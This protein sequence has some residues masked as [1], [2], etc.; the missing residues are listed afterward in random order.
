MVSLLCLLL[1]Q[2]RQRNVTIFQSKDQKHQFRQLQNDFVSMIRN[3]NSKHAK[4]YKQSNGSQIT[5]GRSGPSDSATPLSRDWV[6][7]PISRGSNFL[8]RQIPNF[9]SRPNSFN[10][11]RKNGYFRLLIHHSKRK[12]GFSESGVFANKDEVSESGRLLDAGG[13]KNENADGNNGNNG[14]HGNPDPT[15]DETEAIL[16]SNLQDSPLQQLL[17]QQTK[18]QISLECLNFNLGQ[19]TQCS[20][21][22]FLSE[23]SCSQCNL[24]FEFFQNGKCQ[25]CT[26]P[27]V[28][29]SSS[30][31]CFLCQ[32]SFYLDNSACFPCPANCKVCT[33]SDNCVQC[34]A[35]YVFAKSSL[36]C[37]A[38]PN[39]P[40]PNTGDTSDPGPDSTVLVIPPTSNASDPSA[41][42]DSSATDI[43]E[44]SSGNPRFLLLDN[45]PNCYLQNIF[46][47]CLIC[48]PFFFLR[49][50]LCS[51]CTSNCIF[52]NDFKLCVKCKP[53]F[54][55]EFDPDQG[56]FI[57]A[58]KE[59]FSIQLQYYSYISSLFGY[60]KKD[61]VRR[62][63]DLSR[64]SKFLKF[65]LFIGPII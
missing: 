16:P 58:R 53:D 65:H 25:T 52:C 36:T 49:E 10:E 62:I 15:P 2:T 46:T 44:S 43:F 14:N 40:T 23:G 55:L 21:N 63:F 42:S 54:N 45:I 60:I 27:C 64:I 4:T 29:C 32:S 50:K 1:S 35:S 34:I 7:H 20:Q 51:P 37:E 61:P 6:R 30:S 59:V 57:C 41:N 24:P 47:G 33:A 18:I 9:S 13:I 28:H 56:A 12:P 5:E 11:A 38:D 17:N 3:T 22:Y 39:N 19:C 48:R 26:Q 31:K 8:Y